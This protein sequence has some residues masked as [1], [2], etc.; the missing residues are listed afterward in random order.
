LRTDPKVGLARTE[1]GYTID[2][3]HSVVIE[4][5]Q[6]PEGYP[7]NLRSTS[8]R[9]IG[10]FEGRQSGPL[11]HATFVFFS[12]E[13]IAGQ[14]IKVYVYTNQSSDISEQDFVDFVSSLTFG[15]P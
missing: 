8:P 14:R 15:D 11:P 12:G 6:E 7:E 4:I 5:F 9:T 1:Q 2:D 10:P 3:G 13:E